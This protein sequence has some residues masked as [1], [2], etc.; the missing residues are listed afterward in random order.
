MKLIELTIPDT[1]AGERLLPVI[2]RLA[3]HIAEYWVRNAFKNRDVKLDQVR[4]GR[5]TT[6]YGG[7]TVQI[8]LPETARINPPEIVY[9]D[10]HLL[11]INKPAGVSSD[12]QDGEGLTISEL[13]PLTM[14]GRFSGPLLPCHRLDNQTGGLL[15]LAKD[16][17]SRAAM[18]A[19][20]RARQVHKQYT[21]L[22]F[23]TPQPPHALLEAYLVKDAARATVTVLD[24]PIH[25]ARTIRTEYQV[26]QAGDVARLLITLHT[27]RTHQIRAHLAHIGHPL[28]GDDKYGDRAQ[29]KLHS[30][31]HLMLLATDLQ[32]TITGDFA[33]LNEMHL[34]IPDTL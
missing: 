18:E 19:A 4:V 8:Y 20:F 34:R 1:M 16:E 26:L 25:G 5:D 32:F 22:V 23:G 10:E 13:I 7:E 12:A 29:N 9:E 27:G 2:R 3:P 31:R 21:C 28:L 33:Y 11:V 6:V 17:P 15:L 24:T 14:P 30:A